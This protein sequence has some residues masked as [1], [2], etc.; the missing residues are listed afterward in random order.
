MDVEEGTKEEK[1]RRSRWGENTAPETERAH[2][3][4]FGRTVRG[5][6][7]HKENEVLG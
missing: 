4:E 3:Q 7:G 6:G 5:S 2:Y 1:E